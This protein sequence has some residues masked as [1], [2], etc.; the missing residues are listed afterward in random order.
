M[1]RWVPL[2]HRCFFEDTG[3]QKSTG[4]LG[5]EAVVQCHR[6]HRRRT[7]RRWCTHLLRSLRQHRMALYRGLQVPCLPRDLWLLLL[8]ILAPTP[9][10]IAL[11]YPPRPQG[12]GRAAESWRVPPSG[13]GGSDD[14]VRAQTTA[15]EVGS[16]KAGDWE[17][18]FLA[19]S[20]AGGLPERAPS[21]MFTGAGD[22]GGPASSRA[23]FLQERAGGTG[24]EAAVA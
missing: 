14:G 21:M 3:G 10:A 20:A 18:A 5:P 22:D 17:T 24:I 9:T 16:E 19:G 8:P 23:P 7:S 15:V 4:A 2:V 6:R 1:H 11:L 12:P 13:T